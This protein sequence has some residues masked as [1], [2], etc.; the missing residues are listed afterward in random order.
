MYS[1]PHVVCPLYSLYPCVRVRASLRVSTNNR[2]LARVSYTAYIHIPGK[3]TYPHNKALCLCARTH[4]HTCQPT[5]GRKTKQRRTHTPPGIPAVK[6]IGTR[7]KTSAWE[8]LQRKKNLTTSTN[9]STP[10]RGGTVTKPHHREG[11]ASAVP[12]CFVPRAVRNT[13]TAVEQL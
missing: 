11:V 1:L 13:H 4:T 2:K 12:P 8:Q 7:D 3:Q 6:L 9:Q 5:D 10:S